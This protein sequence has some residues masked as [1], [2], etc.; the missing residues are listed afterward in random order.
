[1]NASLSI[2]YAH[3]THSKRCFFSFSYWS[4][5]TPWQQ[6]R[7]GRDQYQVATRRGGVGGGSAYICSDW[8]C[9]DCPSPCCTLYWVAGLPRWGVAYRANAIF[10]TRGL[11]P[12]Q[13][14]SRGW[15][16]L[17]LFPVLPILVDLAATTITTVALTYNQQ[18]RGGEAF[19]EDEITLI[20]VDKKSF[21]WQNSYEYGWPTRLEVFW[22]IQAFPSIS[23]S[24]ST[25][26]N[27]RLIAI[28]S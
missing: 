14:D 20:V 8:S 19:V 15:L 7:V 9:I 25:S 16:S 27:Y 13:Q 28:E 23:I 2:L 6:D 3:C 17:A 21:W 11:G 1:M 10:S 26:S 22:H 18:K 5:H 24:W 12:C 4:L